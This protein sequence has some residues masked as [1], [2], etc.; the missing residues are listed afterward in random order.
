MN[1][2]PASSSVAVR[3]DPT[4]WD[5]MLRAMWLAAVTVIGVLC[6]ALFLRRLAGELSRPLGGTALIALGLLACTVVA[7]LRGTRPAPGQAVAPWWELA[8]R[9][10]IPGSCALLFGAAI[11]LPASP[12]YARVVFWTILIASEIGWWFALFRRGIGR[13]LERQ[14]RRPPAVPVPAIPSAFLELDSGRNAVVE[15]S[16]DAEES[17]DESLPDSVNQQLTRM[18]TEDAGELVFGLVR[19]GFAVGERSQIIHVAFC[20]PLE[21]TPLF[22]AEQVDGSPVTIKATQV[23]SFGVRLELKRGAKADCAESVVV[24]FEATWQPQPE[25]GGDQPAR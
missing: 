2:Q 9:L 5:P 22:H 6:L 25:A 17:C 8:E 20:P 13:V 4:S 12:P 10:L 21:G 24:R 15:L 1:V 19:A 14:F 18:Q 16:D 3:H 23:E 7:I 11:A